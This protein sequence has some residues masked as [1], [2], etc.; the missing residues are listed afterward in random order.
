MIGA[1]VQPRSLR[2]T[3]MPSRSL[4][5]R[6]KI[7]RSG[8]RRAAG[9]APERCYAI[10]GV[11]GGPRSPGPPGYFIVVDG[12]AAGDGRNRLHRSSLQPGWIASGA[13]HNRPLG[14]R[15][16]HGQPS[17]APAA[18]RAAGLLLAANARPDEYLRGTIRSSL[19]PPA[20]S[21]Y[22]KKVLGRG[23]NPG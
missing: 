13:L 5:P 7:T 12:L 4:C 16:H 9:S 20:K 15:P 23:T 19:A 6:P 21:N 18:T 1:S 11:S 22:T 10:A 8:G 2:M 3:S 14:R 17:S